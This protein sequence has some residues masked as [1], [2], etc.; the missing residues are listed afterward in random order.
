MQ[1]IVGET[2]AGCCRSPADSYIHKG[3]ERKVVKTGFLEE[4]CVKDKQ[5]L[6]DKDKLKNWR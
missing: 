6:V 4:L 1:R 2:H 5:V 3:G